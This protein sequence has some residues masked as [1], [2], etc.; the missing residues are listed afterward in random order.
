[1]RSLNFSDKYSNGPF[2]LL[3]RHFFGRLFD[4]EIVSPGG[5]MA[6]SVA[7]VMAFLPLPG[8]IL[9]LYYLCMKYT[10]KIAHVKSW[11]AVDSWSDRCFFISFAMIVMALATLLNWDT[12]F[13]DRKDYT[14]LAVLPVKLRTLFLAKVTSLI[15]F[16]TLFAVLTNGASGVLFPLAATISHATAADG[17]R[18]LG[19]HFVSVF[20]ASVFTF[21]FLVGMQGACMAFLSRRLLKKISVTI[22]CSLLVLVLSSFLIM[23]DLIVAVRNT[24]VQLYQ[25][26]FVPAWFTALYDR[27][28]GIRSIHATHVSWSFAV[29]ALVTALSLAG[30]F[31][32]LTYHRHLGFFSQPEGR[33][34][35]R[36]GLGTA[37]LRRVRR[38]VTR[39]PEEG[40]AFDFVTAT[41]ARSA[42]HRIVL[43]SCLGVALAFCLSAVFLLVTRDGT[44]SMHRVNLTVLCLPAILNLLLLGG[45]R[46]SFSLPSELGAN[47]V[48]RIPPFRHDVFWRGAR[49]AVWTVVLAP[50]FIV[51]LVVFSLCWGWWSALRFGLLQTLC[52]LVLAEWLFLRFPKIPFTCSYLPGSADLK[53]RWPLYVVLFAGYLFFSSTLCVA[54]AS[55]PRGY[56]L[57]LMI[58]VLLLLAL[59]RSRR[60]FLLQRRPIFEDHNGPEFLKLGLSSIR[61]PRPVDQVT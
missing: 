46:F 36:L 60:S 41:L 48:F 30:I 26:M 47:W 9:S 37:L 32:A 27:L 18:F 52:A 49:I 7:Q 58:G 29:V 45:V 39:E 23:S 10:F 54:M 19:A 44:A 22:Q 53:S 42:R 35:S 33:T 55:R 28:L 31:Y 2:V 20:S 13:P 25:V 59:F 61:S 40:A 11:A 17:F 15:L 12:L 56:L 1:M 38:I 50:V 21:L 14:N 3:T 43:G 4:N 16:M 6:F 51:T 8:L 34:D 24:Q 5:D 57:T